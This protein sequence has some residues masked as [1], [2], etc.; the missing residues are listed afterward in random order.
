MAA[1]DYT[2]GAGVFGTI[3]L[4]RK[5]K[6]RKDGLHLMSLDRRPLEENEILY[7]F[8]NYLRHWCEENKTDT[9]CVSGK[10]GKV[11]FEAVLKSKEDEI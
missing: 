4:T 2:F 5:T 10:D 6:P 11:L 7:I 8:E 9:L 3:Y 1:K